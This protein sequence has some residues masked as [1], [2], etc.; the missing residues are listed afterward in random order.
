MQE[1]ANANRV[2]AP[3]LKRFVR[4]VLQTRHVPADDATIVADCLV[5]ANLSGID[6]HGV[7]RLAHYLRRLDNGTIKAA[8]EIV[9]DRSAPGVLR[10]DGGDG[11]GHVVT[12]RAADRARDICKEQGSV[13]VS[14]ANSSHF[15]PAS[16]FLLDAVKEGL[17]GMVVT[18]TDRLVVPHGAG[19]PFFGTNPVAFGFP[20]PDAPFMLDISTS[21]IA[22]GHIA[23]S[24]V[25]GKTI[26]DHWAVDA[27]GRPTTDPDAVEGMH[28][29]A[30]H[31]GSG[32]AFVVDI[33]SALFSGMAFGPH[34]NRM[35]HEMEKPRKLGHFLTF[36]DIG[37]FVAVEQFVARMGEMIEEL[38]ALPLFEG[39]S[40]VYYPGEMEGERRVDRA[41]RGIP[42]EEGLLAEL[43]GVAEDAAIS[44]P[45]V[46]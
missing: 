43:R 42:L 45:T 27:E 4:E 34:I 2:S 7:V 41:N 25:E 24:K 37:R 14:V 3:E 1:S 26:P 20:A 39:F 40:R 22:F 33:L 23:L 8:P 9:F 30:G 19:R 16:Y 6:S 17:G 28:P 21:T 44:P 11:L 5:A 36:W 46:L 31:K 35:Y 32:L 15:G 18:H 13:A 10:V 38:H 12:K 29:M